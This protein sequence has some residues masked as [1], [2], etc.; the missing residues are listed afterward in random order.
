M[1]NEK[2]KVSLYLRDD[3]YE[4]VKN[5]FRKDQCS[6]YTEFMERAITYY[7]G[8]VNSSRM[9]DYLSPT[10][11]SS[12]RAVSNE[13]TLRISHILFKLAVEIAIMNNLYAA[14]LNVDPNQLKE[15]RE[16]CEKEVR[17]LRGD[18]GIENAIRWQKG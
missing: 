15:L 13:N 4:E 8:Y 16:E 17:L 10:I 18:F 7:L 2:K 14:S 1:D 12:I 11:M 9:T 3:T 5:T 6:S